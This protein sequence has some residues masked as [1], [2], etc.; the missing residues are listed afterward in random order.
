VEIQVKYAGYIAKQMA[1]VERMRKLEA[2]RIPP[3]IDYF[4]IP[5][6]AYEAREK[7]SKIRPLN[8]GQASRISGV[9]PSDIS[10]LLVYL[11]QRKK[12]A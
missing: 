11:E 9:N 8:I 7:L 6:L 4:K 5:G 1:E 12:G 3:D 2:K 10:V